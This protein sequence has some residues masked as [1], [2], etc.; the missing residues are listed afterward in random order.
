MPERRSQDVWRSA[1]SQIGGT[2]CA[3]TWKGQSM[4]VRYR[5]IP[6][7]LPVLAG[8][9]VLSVL[10]Q[11]RENT[12]QDSSLQLR[13]EARDVRAGVP[14]RFVFILVNRGLH[15]VVV[16]KPSVECGD[17]FNGT[18]SVHLDFSPLHPSTESEG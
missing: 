18:V 2:Q 10:V 12:A 5:R 14:E 1:K 6:R 13:L 15:D 11:A 3:A 9:L 17:L 16:P 7:T 4:L 8:V